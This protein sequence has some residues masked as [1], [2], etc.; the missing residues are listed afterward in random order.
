MGSYNYLG[1][2]ENTGP[3]TDAAAKS[4]KKYGVGIGSSRQEIGKRRKNTRSRSHWLETIVIVFMHV[5]VEISRFNL[6]CR[7]TA[8]AV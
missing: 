3:C 1:F 5:H 6:F 4:I 2:A 8:I 7:M